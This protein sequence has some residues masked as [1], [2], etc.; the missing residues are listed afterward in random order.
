MKSGSATWVWATACLLACGCTTVA[1]LDRPYHLQPD[2]GAGE[3]GG[4]G[5]SAP[6]DAPCDV[7]VSAGCVYDRCGDVPDSAPAGAYT[8]DPDGTGPQ[9][10]LQVH[11]GEP[12]VGG[13]WALVYNSV[14]ELDGPTPA[15]WK[16][17]YAARLDAKGEPSLDNNHYQPGL[18]LAGREYRDE[19]ED[20]PG[21]VAEVLRATAEGINPENMQLLAPVRVTGDAELFDWQFGTGWSSQ[22]FDGDT[23][24]DM[25]C[26]NAYA[27]VTQHYGYCFVYSLGADGDEP[28]EGESIAEVIADEDWGPHLETALATSHGL[29]NDGSDYT[30]VKRIS[31][32]TRW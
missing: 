8:I 6:A 15:F 13:R 17:L 14:G 23:L 16:I 18:Y 9:E 5:G 22:D 11:C 32:W 25:N 21:T 10:P 2:G 1:G 20:I 30:R 24:S 19:V 4:S 29:S 27:G 28:R 26:A 7:E 3:A 31:R 12:V